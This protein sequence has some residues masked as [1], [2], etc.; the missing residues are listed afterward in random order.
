MRIT[1]EL[2]HR[3]RTVTL[4]INNS[5]LISSLIYNIVDKSSSEYAERLHNQGYR[6]QNRAFKLFTFS[7]L[8]PGNRRK[9][10]MHENGTMSTAEALLH[11]T[12]S[13]PKEEFI[14]HLVIGL[15]HE[16]YVWIGNERFRVETV[17]KLDQPELIGDMEFIMLS[18]LVCTTK[19]EP[20]QYPQY[21]YP[22][23]QEFERVLLENLCRKYQALHG[24]SFSCESG[25][26]D[27]AIDEAYVERMH[28]KVQKLIT[29]KE[30]RSDETKIKGTLAPFRLRAPRELMEIGYECGFGEKNSMGFGMVKPYFRLFEEEEELVESVQ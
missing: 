14:E 18:P 24:R 3:K 19:R 11:V 22:G 6:L 23:D 28:G 21:L 26:F 16:P 12:I 20:D 9:W 13:S 25:Q 27:F 8:Y 29:L 17:R 30:G 5:H 1:L 10:V 2:S 4:P 15:L 7:P